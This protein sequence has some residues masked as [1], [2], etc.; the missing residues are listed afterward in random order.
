VTETGIDIFP[1]RIWDMNA[2]PK[3]EKVVPKTD[4]TNKTVGIEN[5]KPYIG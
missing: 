3:T 2:K 5:Q 4:S 1:P